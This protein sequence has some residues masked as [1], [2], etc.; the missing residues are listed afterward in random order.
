MNA[1][2]TGLMRGWRLEKNYGNYGA[3]G[4]GIGLWHSKAPTLNGRKVGE[5]YIVAQFGPWKAMWTKE[6]MPRPGVK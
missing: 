3:Y 4:W 5:A 6:F 2:S 1:V